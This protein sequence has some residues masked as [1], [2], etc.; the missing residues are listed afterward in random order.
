MAF[1][2]DGI[3]YLYAGWVGPCLWNEGLFLDDNLTYL[4]KMRLVK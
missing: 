1:E 4:Q 2:M 3:G